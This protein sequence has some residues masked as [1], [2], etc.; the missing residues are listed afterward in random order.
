MKF[1]ARQTAVSIAIT[2][3][4]GIALADDGKVYPGSMAVRI[5]G[6]QPDPALSYGSVANP[7]TT[8]WLYLDLP[9]IHDSIDKSIVNGWVEVIDRHPSYSIRVRLQS[10]YRTGSSIYGWW[11]PNKYSTGSST[12]K[13]RLSV[14]GLGA[15]SYGHYFYGASIPPSYYGGRSTIISYKVSEDTCS[16]IFC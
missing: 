8:Q 10:V 15:K 1:L 3:I 5:S 12:S 16:A 2:A 9:V 4:T 6:T 7:S 13:Q 11:G 14:P